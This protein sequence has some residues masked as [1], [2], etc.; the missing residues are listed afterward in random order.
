M[1]EYRLLTHIVNWGPTRVASAFGAKT[2]D[3]LRKF[4]ANAPPPSK[5]WRWLACAPKHR[6]MRRFNRKTKTKTKKILPANH[7][8]RERE[9]QSISSNEKM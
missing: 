7:N 4:A 1:N 3:E 8:E 6:E 2:C 9:N 5:L